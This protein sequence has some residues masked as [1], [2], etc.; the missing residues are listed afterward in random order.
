VN[1]K[2]VS[3][4]FAAWVAL[5]ALSIAFVDRA[6][7]SWSYAHL[8]A[9]RMSAFDWATHL[10][11]PLQA[12]ALAALAVIG[13]RALASDWRPAGHW[14]TLLI[15]AVAVL[16][17]VAFKEQLKYLFGRT[18]P[19]TWVNHNPSW[20]GSGAYGFHFHHGGA[21]WAS[22]PSGHLTQSSAVGETLWLRAPKLRWLAILFPLL[23][24][25]GLFGCDYHFVGDMI[26]GGFLGAGVALAAA[27]LLG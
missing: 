22:F 7:S 12:L 19:E 4:Y 11:D 9:V 16:V 24:A 3:W 13:V 17:A 27:R 8:H 21:G 23:V 10:V 2:T 5:S 25:I 6:A 18:W 15:G 14:R 20:I 26:A 1:A